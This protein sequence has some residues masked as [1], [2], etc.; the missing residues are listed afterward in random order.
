MPEEYPLSRDYVDFNRLNLQHYIWKDMFGYSLHPKIPRNQK[1]LKIAD[2]GTGTGIWLL[3]LLPQLDPSTELVGI[4]ADIT[5]VGPREWLPENLTLRQWSVFTD[6]PDDLVGAFDIVNLRLFAFVIE[7]DATLLLRKLKKLLKPGGYLQWCDVDVLSFR[8]NTASS[9]VSTHHLVQLW[10]QTMPKEARLF[11]AWVKG[12]PESF[13]NEGFLDITTDWQAQKGHTGIAMHWCN[14][15]IHEMLA[16]RLRESDPEKSP[17]IREVME[18]A[19]VESRK[20]AMYAFDR[21]VV[22]GQKP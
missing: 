5:Q 8:I 16:D 10:E 18:A 22:V 12:L 14:L 2:V 15:P 7:D 4:D 1:S 3:D 13:E 9:N 21:L 17:K 19:S 6:V 20:G 11:P